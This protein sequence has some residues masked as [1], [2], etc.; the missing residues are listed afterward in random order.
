MPLMALLLTLSPQTA[1]AYTYTGAND[2]TTPLT[3]YSN[4]DV[5]GQIYIVFQGNWKN[6]KK[7]NFQF[8][9]LNS[10][11]GVANT[12]VDGVTLADA[13]TTG[14]FKWKSSNYYFWI[15]STAG[16]NKN[17][18]VQV[19]L[20]SG[21]TWNVTK[22]HWISIK[23]SSSTGTKNIEVCGNIMSLVDGTNYS[24]MT[25]IPSEYCFYRLFRDSVKSGP[26][27]SNVKASRLL[28][29]A[30]TLKKGCYEEM[31]SG[32]GSYLIAAG[33]PTE[34]PA[35]N[36]VH[37]CYKNMFKG[38][39]TIT[40]TPAIKALSLQDCDGD[41]TDCCA[42]MFNGCTNV[43][44]VT[45][46]F[47]DWGSTTGP[48]LN[49]I[50]STK[51]I[52]FNCPSTLTQTKDANHMGSNG[53]KNASVS[54]NA[55]IFDVHTNLGTWD[56]SC[57]IDKY[58][59]TA[60]PS[61]SDPNGDFAGWY[62]ASSGGSPITPGSLGAPSGLTTYYAQFNS[63][64]TKKVTITTPSNGTIT[65]SW[66]DGSAH[67]FT[68]GNQDIAENTSLTISAA[69]NT[70]YTLTGITIT[71]SGESAV[72]HTSGNTYTLTKDITVAATF[73]TDECSI[74][75]ANPTP[76]GY[77][78][79]S[80]SDGINSYTVGQTHTFNRQN[81][82][83]KVL[84]VTAVPG[85]ERV[86][87]SWVGGLTQTGTNPYTATY[88]IG[89]ST[90]STLT[91]GATFDVKK[92]TINATSSHGTVNLTAGGY[93]AAVNTGNYAKNVSVT[94]TPV[95]DD[96]YAFARWSDD[97][98]DNPRTITV[99]D[100]LTLSAVF[101]EHPQSDPASVDVYQV[102]TGAG[103][104]KI[105]YDLS[106]TTD[107]TNPSI[108]YTPIDLGYGV[109]WADRNIGATSTTNA[110]GYFYYGGTTA[111]YPGTAGSSSVYYSG[112]GSMAYN[113]NL[114]ME[115]DAA[116]QLMGG[117]TWRIPTSTEWNQLLNNGAYNNTT[118]SANF[119]AAQASRTGNGTITSK[120]D[121]S[122]SITLPAA[123]VIRDQTYT[124]MSTYMCYWS[125]T[126][127][128]TSSNGGAIPYHL[129][130]YNGKTLAS[131]S[132]NALAWHSLPIRAIYSPR[133]NQN[134]LTIRTI[135]GGTTYTY[136]YVCEYGQE[137]IVT[138]NANTGSNYV[139]N[140]W[141]EDHNTNAT[142]TFT[143][144]SDMTYTATFTQATTY[145][146]TYNAGANGT[147][148]IASGSKIQGVD[149]T[150][151]SS[152]FTRTGYTQSGWSTSDGGAKVYNLGG[153]YTTDAAI[154]LYPYWTA[155]T[156]QVSF[157]AGDG[158]GAAMANQNFSY[159]E[160]KALSANTYIG[161]E[162]TVTYNYNG[163]TG[164]IG[165]ASATV[166][167]WFDGWFDEEDNYYDDEQ[168]VSDLTTENGATIAMTASWGFYEEVTLPNPTKTGYTLNQWSGI[169]EGG[170]G[171]VGDG[172]GD[173]MVPE[174]GITLTAQWTP[175][176]YNL[177]YT[178]LEGASNSNPATYTIETATFALANPGTRAG[179]TFT[180]WTCGGNPITQITIGSTGD[181]TITANWSTNTHNV[182]WVTDGNA[183]T[184]TYT[185]G[186]TAYGTTIV[187]PN[188]PTKNATAEYT[189][190]FNGWS[191]AVDATM[192]D[193]DVTYT[194]Q[195]TATPVNYTLTWDFDGG[196]TVTAV[197][198]YTNGTVAYGTTIVAPADPTKEGCTFNGWDVTPAGT[199]PAANTTYTAQWTAC[200]TELHI[201]LD[202]H[203]EDGDDYYDDFQKYN[204]VTATTVTLNRQ[205]GKGK[206]ATLCLPFEVS[207]GQ[208]TN[209]R[210]KGRV[211]EFR[212][213]EGNANDGNQVTL[214]FAQAE[215]LTAG[216][217]YIVNANAK[218]AELTQFVFHNVTINTSAD[219]IQPLNSISQYNDLADMVGYSD[220]TGTIQLV[221]TLRLGTLKG[222]NSGNT[223][224]GLKDNKIY[225]PSTSE[226]GSTVWAYR[227]VFRSTSPLGA[228]RI[229][230][231]VEGD[232]GEEVTE[233]EVINGELQQ[234]GAAKKFVQDGVLYIEREGVIYDAQGKLRIE[235]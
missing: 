65:V 7:P 42:G 60:A 188:T 49:W 73:A 165:V 34:L 85:E 233:L 26:A 146:V 222:S 116:Y 223:Y 4:G 62:T 140:E 178:G 27:C 98:T 115:A 208:M 20:K 31:F 121:P 130:I 58:A 21:E 210:M 201:V 119:T 187:A 164:G 102:G 81:D 87:E 41:I 144:T 13:S 74:T 147:G 103:A 126:L 145:T 89:A 229:R 94:L 220:G 122:K 83:G 137:V 28:L 206:W 10:S 72:A 2:A 59:T 52:T 207:G 99:T 71:P 63:A 61:I 30:T 189:Y 213:A 67:S 37:S 196:S 190:A 6:V 46:S 100:N 86:F 227:G 69:P 14:E 33:V 159:G 109:A 214:F 64:A 35:A 114:P 181:K 212:H 3:F 136:I 44:T 186:T 138:A 29:P 90:P 230:I 25:E 32:V 161:P 129:Y 193:N 57:S 219:Q 173:F 45:T 172:G 139:F 104:T 199:M 151:T 106:P 15:N 107:V 195:W 117:N 234:A 197:G 157:D 153:T 217:A 191:P 39:T 56:G 184:G 143:V 142:R 134:T 124:Q 48:T 216:K 203:A 185:N 1:R 47:L 5:Y 43:A 19:R 171:L 202:E 198:D 96:F 235:N 88:T 84:T 141:S 152:T 183:L 180:G 118:L 82:N 40:S 162:A 92:Y 120:T 70:G 175:V 16:D 12:W 169:D 204:G 163:A 101:E 23:F 36:L 17:Y 133:F 154:T 158:S 156:Y 209:L 50:T 179:Y 95:A 155:N 174:G 105:L 125:S 78:T 97:N 93:D 132:G 205:F 111:K 135:N 218:L 221:G 79:I 177:T 200:A 127:S 148:S 91:I 77:G 192:P 24:T 232:E 108:T 38:C 215:K 51:S 228:Q 76:A 131:G 9:T 176:T 123:G 128:V 22:D 170:M 194:A 55:Y 11:S 168:E 66:N 8:R 53:T 150:L 231:V 75:I 149:F 113:D 166:N 54:P 110:G 18:G 80:V 211:Y 182:S 68:S 225:Y 224:M 112:I 226:P 160:T 167:A